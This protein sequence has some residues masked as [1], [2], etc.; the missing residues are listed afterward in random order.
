M[1]T[2]FHLT[3]HNQKELARCSH[4]MNKKVPTRGT[5]SATNHSTIVAT[6]YIFKEVMMPHSTTRTAKLISVLYLLFGL[7]LS[8]AVP[9]LDEL[10]SSM[11]SNWREDEL[12]LIMA[13]HLPGYAWLITF[14][15]LSVT[16]WLAH[17][18]TEPK[19]AQTISVISGIVLFVL[20]A[21]A[22][23][24]INMYAHCHEWG[25]GVGLLPTW[26]LFN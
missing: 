24:W 4:G 12:L 17:R 7:F 8:V 11:F 9:K 25:C 18:Y 26:K 6:T 1:Q 10:Y 16:L 23:D 15:T 21:H 19:T 14:A 20:A 3:P 2:T 22:F 5:G 13:F